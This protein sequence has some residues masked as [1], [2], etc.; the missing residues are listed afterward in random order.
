MWRGRGCGIKDVFKQ[1]EMMSRTKDLS[2][3]MGT[4]SDISHM[5]RRTS[6]LRVSQSRECSGWTKIL[7][8]VRGNHFWQK[9]S[10]KPT[11]PT[12]SPFRTH[13]IY[14]KIGW[15]NIYGLKYNDKDLHHFLLFW[16]PT[17][18]CYTIFLL[19]SPL[20]LYKVSISINSLTL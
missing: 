9:S 6:A 7:I 16:L 20:P 13:A 10:Q 19:Q 8:I 11:L 17:S 4:C 1:L 15:E 3:I 14:M 2:P 12:S 5:P 18:T